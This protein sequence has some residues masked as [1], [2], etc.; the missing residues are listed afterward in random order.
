MAI[1]NFISLYLLFILHGYESA[2]SFFIVHVVIIIYLDVTWIAT[3]II[4]PGIIDLA[5][6]TEYPCQLCENS[7]LE[8]INMTN[9]NHCRDC[10]TCI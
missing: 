9:S 8:I 6:A 10:E 3:G 7:N 1:I 2:Y 4:N 5:E